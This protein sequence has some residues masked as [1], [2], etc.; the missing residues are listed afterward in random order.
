MPRIEIEDLPVD[1]A[2]VLRRRAR[3]AGMPVTEYLRAEL[4]ARARTRVPDDAVVE[5][6]ATQG[7]ELCCE[8][9]ADAVALVDTYDLPVEALDRY[10]R[11]AGATGLSLGEYVRGQLISLARRTSVDDAL[12]EFREA[13]RR[14]PNLVVDMEAI[15]ASIRYVHGE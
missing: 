5:F 6:L 7:R 15:E 1:S 11:R 12:E 2:D 3:V 14:D 10:G 4:I 9:D 13:R 8:W